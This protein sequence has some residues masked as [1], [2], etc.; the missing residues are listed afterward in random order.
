MFENDGSLLYARAMLH[1]RA[2][3][4]D[5]ALADLR[6]VLDDAPADARA[7]NAYGY[8]LVE[9]RQDYAAALPLL[10]RAHALQ[11]ESAPILDSLGWV[12]LRL[13][14]HERALTL[15]RDAW[16]RE[17]DPEIAAHYGEALWIAGRPDEARAVWRAGAVL[18]PDHPALKRAM[19]IPDR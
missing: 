11:P 4:A 13:G 16:A 9:A 6:R 19:E 3:R 12:N 10:E 17:K 5:A 15:L 18:D 2:G 14:R 7:L 1:E 8:L